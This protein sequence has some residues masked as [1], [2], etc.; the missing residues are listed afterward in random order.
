MGGWG[1]GGGGCT[2]GR[3]KIDAIIIATC[4]SL[5]KSV[6]IFM[7]YHICIQTVTVLSIDFSSI[8]GLPS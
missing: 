7:V 1:G 6:K 2:A 4:K 8:D 5:A 3:F